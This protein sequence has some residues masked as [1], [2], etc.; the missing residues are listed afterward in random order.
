MVLRQH[1]LESFDKFWVDNLHG[2][3]K[4]TEYA[5]DGKTSETIFAISGFSVGIQQGVATSL[6]VK[7]GKPRKAASQVWFRRSN[8]AKAKDRRQQLLDSLKAKNLPRPTSWP[9]EPENRFPP[10]EEVTEDYAA[11]PKIITCAK[12][13]SN[14]LMEKRGGALID[15][16]RDALKPQCGITSCR[17]VWKS[18]R[19]GRW[20]L[21]ENALRLQCQ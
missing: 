5:P 2:N 7:T 21:T 16:E 10:T 19:H 13:P 8:S 4:I 6:W 14:G 20:Q 12:S 15:V 11:W 17:F 18:I 1:L 9:T 3:R